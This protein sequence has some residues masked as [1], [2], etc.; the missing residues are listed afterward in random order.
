M[1]LREFLEVVNYDEFNIYVN[2]NKTGCLKS[3]FKIDK[4]TPIKYLSGQLLD[5]KIV[6]VFIDDENEDNGLFSIEIEEE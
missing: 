6:E 3:I 4:D 1:I 5:S 2:E